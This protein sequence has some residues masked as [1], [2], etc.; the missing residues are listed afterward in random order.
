[1]HVPNAEK[2]QGEINTTLEDPAP[3]GGGFE[4][5]VLLGIK[6]AWQ[7]REECHS[8]KIWKG[9]DFSRGR[10]RGDLQQI[11]ML[12][13]GKIPKVLHKFPQNKERVGGKGNSSS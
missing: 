1:M 4:G 11:G 9:G 6:G 2:R 7:S 3:E 8:N 5:L 10:K 13:M 12:I